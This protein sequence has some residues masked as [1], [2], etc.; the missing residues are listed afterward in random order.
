MRLSSTI[1]KVSHAVFNKKN[2]KLLILIM[3]LALLLFMMLGNYN[4]VNEGMTLQEEMQKKLD[5]VNTGNDVLNKTKD[6]E[7]HYHNKSTLTVNESMNNRC[8]SNFSNI[9]TNGHNTANLAVNTQCNVL[10][11]LREKNNL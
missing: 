3:I 7:N 11:A 10:K 4:L 9:G 8:S 6:V 5:K 2:Y 1:K